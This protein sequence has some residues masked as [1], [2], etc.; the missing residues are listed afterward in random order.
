ML[1]KCKRYVVD[2]INCP[3][4]SLSLLY[5]CPLIYDFVA[6]PPKEFNYISSPFDFGFGHMACFVQK[7]EKEVTVCHFQ[8]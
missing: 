3:S 5:S 4:S 1:R 6:P 8:S 7:N 2:V